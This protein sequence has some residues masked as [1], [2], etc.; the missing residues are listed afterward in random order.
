M[1]ITNFPVPYVPGNHAPKKGNWLR[2]FRYLWLAL[3]YYVLIGITVFFY[4]QRTPVYTSSFSMVLPGSGSSSNFSIEEVG[5]ASQSTQQAF[6]SN[7][8][9][10]LVNYKTIMQGREVKLKV[11]NNLRLDMGQLSTP[12]VELRERTSILTVTTEFG[13][14][15]AAQDYG[16]QAYEGFQLTLDELRA[17]EA[18]RRDESVRS[19]LAQYRQRL[20]D[21]RQAIVEFQQRSL[22]ISQVQ[23]GQLMDTISDQ[24]EAHS[25]LLASKG[26]LR[27][28]VRKLSMDLGISA[29][30]AGQA[31][32]L[33]SDAQF[34]SYLRQVDQSAGL[35]AE[36]SSR[37][38]ERHP[39]VVAQQSR[40]DNAKRELRQRSIE[41]IGRDDAD[42]IVGLDLQSSTQRADLFAKLV[43]KTAEL[44]G[45]IA[46]ISEVELN[47]N[48]LRDQL[49]V[50]SREAAELE[51]LERE[52]SLA[53]AVFTSAAAKLEASQADIFVSYPIIQLL[54]VPSLS[55]QAKSPSKTIAVGIAALGFLL[56]T[57]GLAA[58]WHR[59][60]LIKVL[61][62]KK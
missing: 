52:H 28:Y 44:E 21:T 15:Q 58:L 27:D 29:S 2:R 32:A 47:Q 40:L 9:N 59:D 56:V 14:P 51:R 13:S 1:G 5:A 31:F 43:E 6:N 54:S 57:F 36:Y 34:R 16:W 50:Y 3:L 33:Q 20:N 17:D 4:L 49:T 10:P 37:W 8:F 26:N 61:L 12:Q 60:Y 45:L 35:L 24:N 23:V 19:V 42:S 53:E 41:L 38:G 55:T 46:Q 25:S 48:K 30:L 7:A 18:F 62:K 11:A 22:L 39:Q